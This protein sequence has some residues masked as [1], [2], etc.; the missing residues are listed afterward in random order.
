MHDEHQASEGDGARAAAR[1]RGR[2]IQRRLLGVEKV[3]ASRGPTLDLAPEFAELLDEANW[4]GVW[5]RPG[6]DLR[7]RSLCVISCMLAQERFEHA[8]VHIAGARR[9]GVTRGELVEV[10]IQLTFYVGIPVMHRG[11]A[12]VAAAYAEPETR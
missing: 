10:V 6:L 11:L 2:E 12:L 5:A 7:T 9:L 8:A 3:Q 1:E 4:G